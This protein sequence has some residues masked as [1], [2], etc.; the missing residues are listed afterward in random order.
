MKGKH[1]EGL[2]CSAPAEDM[3]RQ[4]LS[5]QMAAMCALRKQALSWT[6]P[7]GVHQMRVLSRRLRSAIADFEPYMRKT[8]LPLT[9][10]RTIA[11]SLGAVRDEDVALAALEKLKAETHGAVA[12]GLEVLINERQLLR[13]QARSDLQKALRRA[14][15]NE[16]QEEFENRLPPA[17]PAPEQTPAQTEAARSPTFRSIGARVIRSRLK[18]L[19]AASPH[20]YFPADTKELHELRILTKGLRYSVELFA[21]CWGQD[22]R[23]I[24]KEIAQLQTSLGELHDCDVWMADLGMRLKRSTRRDRTDPDHARTTAASTWLLKHYA[25]VRTEHYRDALGRWQQWQTDG[26]LSSLISLLGSG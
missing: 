1:I 9:R 20:I 21:A 11:R 22:L 16:L 23:A 13:D 18:E 24:A 2:D 6:D 14:E 15:V 26:F 3:I 8:R 5:A 25:K 17:T 19:Q 10:V 12:H 7:E 4:V